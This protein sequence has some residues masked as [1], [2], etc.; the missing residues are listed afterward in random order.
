MHIFG[1]SFRK[2]LSSLGLLT[3]LIFWSSFAEAIPQNISFQTKI[4]K[5]DGTPLEASSVQFRFS[6]MNPLSTCVIYSEN[7]SNVDLSNSA[8]S[9]VLA[10]GA[11]SRAYPAAGLMNWRRPKDD[12]FT[13]WAS[14][15][16]AYLAATTWRL[17]PLILLPCPSQPNCR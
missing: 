3:F 6:L 4:Y 2:A 11:G 1:F 8:G 15:P 17:S 10:L 9:L 14:S 13:S 16:R 12:Q 5:P 7:F